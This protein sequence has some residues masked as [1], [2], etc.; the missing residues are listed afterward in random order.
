MIAVLAIESPL[1]RGGRVPSA[2]VRRRAAFAG[3][4]GFTVVPR[5]LLEQALGGHRGTAIVLR[6]S[7]GADRFLPSLPVTLPGTADQGE[8]AL[9]FCVLLMIVVIGIDRS[10]ASP[11]DALTAGRFERF[12]RR[13]ASDGAAMLSS[14]AGASSGGHDGRLAGS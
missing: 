12:S 4:I 6:R 13:G 9:R 7:S 14:V 8:G 3:W 1:Y 11:R 2:I 5:V 10:G